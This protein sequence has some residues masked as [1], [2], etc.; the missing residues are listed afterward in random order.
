MKSLLAGVAEKNLKKRK[1]TYPKRTN[2]G[3]KS[4][5]AGAIE[6]YAMMMTLLCDYII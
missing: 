1:S 2:E 6:C 5:L 3:K 4:S